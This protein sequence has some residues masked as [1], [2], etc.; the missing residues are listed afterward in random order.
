MS[1]TLRRLVLALLLLTGTATASLA[2]DPARYMS[3]ELIA[4]SL[5]PAPGS[6]GDDQSAGTAP[7]GDRPVAAVTRRN[8][9]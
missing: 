4:E 3:A 5:A 7:T 1:I 8:G 2:A 6:T 9:G